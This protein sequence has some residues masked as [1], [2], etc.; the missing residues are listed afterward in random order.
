MVE[1]VG[2]VTRESGQRRA[3]ILVNLRGRD[4]EGYVKEALARIKADVKFPPGYYYEFGGQ[5]ENLQ[6]ARLRLAEAGALVGQSDHGVSL[7]LYAKDPDG[8]EFEIFWAVP[9]GT[10]VG[11]RA[12][13]LEAEVARWSSQDV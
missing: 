7:S 13:D 2:A 10:S 11:T 12:L 6:R 3:A 4:V 9:G 5:F 8:L 1:A